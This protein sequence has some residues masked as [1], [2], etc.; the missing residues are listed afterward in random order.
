MPG[1]ALCSREG[2]SKLGGFVFLFGDDRL[3]AFSLR[4]AGAKK[5]LAKRNAGK[6]PSSAEDGEGSAPSTAQAFEKA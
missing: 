3:S 4:V 2:K 1:L 6:V 5:K